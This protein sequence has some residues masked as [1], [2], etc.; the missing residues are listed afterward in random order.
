M[1][2]SLKVFFISLLLLA[3]CSTL[4]SDKAPALKTPFGKPEVTVSKITKAQVKEVL[5]MK[6]EKA[7]YQLV[8]KTENALKFRQNCTD[9]WTNF[10]YGTRYGMTNE[11]I[12]NY[13]I[14]ETA[15]NIKVVAD[16]QSI[17][18]PGTGFQQARDLSRDCRL[19]EE[20]QQFLEDAFNVLINK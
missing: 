7:G 11:F 6:M 10:K 20:I 18:N 1:N 15:F 12:V 4:P 9:F 3:G 17:T 14:L 19:A 8:E 5:T 2:N 16:I 13:R